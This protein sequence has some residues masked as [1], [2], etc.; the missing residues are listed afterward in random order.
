MSSSTWSCSRPSSRSEP[1]LLGAGW[2]EG[3]ESSTRALIAVDGGDSRTSAPGAGRWTPRIRHAAEPGTRT[4]TGLPPVVFKAAPGRPRTSGR[5]CRGGA[6]C[7]DGSLP[8]TNVHP[9]PPRVA[10][11]VAVLAGPH[12]MSCARRPPRVR[13]PVVVRV[14]RPPPPW[15]GH[16]DD[17]SGAVI[18]M[19]TGLIA[20]TAHGARIALSAEPPAAAWPVLAPREAGQPAA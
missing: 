16:A 19:P 5:G 13:G 17:L 2:L 20:G 15:P 7:S 4:R 9:E 8:S 10:V 18:P 3:P 1:S 6:S 12:R 11:E 14:H